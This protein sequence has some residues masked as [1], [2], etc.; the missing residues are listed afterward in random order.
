M[1]PGICTIPK[2]ALIKFAAIVF[3]QNDKEMPDEPV[4]YTATGGPITPEG[5][6]TGEEVGEQTVTV[7]VTSNPSITDTSIVTVVDPGASVPT[8][9][10][11]FPERITVSKGGE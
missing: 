9:M 1:F 2:G 3:D 7:K 11:L 6:Y 5:V 10:G 4:T 8:I